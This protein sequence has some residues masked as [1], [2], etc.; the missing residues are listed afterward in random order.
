MLGESETADTAAVNKLIKL[1]V[2]RTLSEITGTLIHYA[3]TGEIS[4]VFCIEIRRALRF[5][6]SLSHWGFLVSSALGILQ[7][8]YLA[9][10]CQRWDVALVQALIYL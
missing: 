6:N 3:G 10:C 7:V 2:P 4:G 8:I 1:P 5:S 9:F